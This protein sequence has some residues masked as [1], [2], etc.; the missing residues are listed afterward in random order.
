MRAICVSFIIGSD[1]AAAVRLA[2]GVALAAQKH[3]LEHFN[4]WRPVLSAV[5]AILLWPLLL[6]GISLHIHR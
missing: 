4:G 2:V 3:Y 5:L 1:T 6:L